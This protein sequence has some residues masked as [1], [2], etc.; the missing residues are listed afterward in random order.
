M[1]NSNNTIGNETHDL[2]ACSTVPQ[3]R[4]PPHAPQIAMGDQIKE[5]EVDETSI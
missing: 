4:V 1:K 5:D 2:L 3:P